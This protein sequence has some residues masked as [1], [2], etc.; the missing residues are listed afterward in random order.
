MDPGSTKTQITFQAVSTFPRIY[1][2][3]TQTATSPILS[4]ACY[5]EKRKTFYCLAKQPVTQYPLNKPALNIMIFQRWEDNYSRRRMSS[6]RSRT[7]QHTKLTQ[8][9]S[10]IRKTLR[11]R[12]GLNPS[13]TLKLVVP[14]DISTETETKLKTLNWEFRNI[15]KRL[16]LLVLRFRSLAQL[17]SQ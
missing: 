17:R 6:V 10:Q 12:F 9:R 16:F 5:T 11:P 7:S 1:L 3:C 15:Q 8:H 13:Q 4:T 2:S 14:R